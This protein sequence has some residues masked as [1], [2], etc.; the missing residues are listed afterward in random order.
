V[1]CAKTAELIKM[2]STLWTLVGPR[3]H[4]L[5]GPRS[6][7]EGAIIRGKDMPGHARR[8]SAVSCAKMA[9]SIDLPFV[10]WTWVCRMKHKFNRIHQ[11]AIMC[12]RGRAHWCHLANTIGPSVCSG[13]VALR[14]ITLTTCC[15]LTLLVDDRQYQIL[16]L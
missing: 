6:L 8:H 12:P 7:F 1:S 13:D 16:Y 4:V 2:S 9:G 11:V 14:Q 10:L 5:D 15:A 3:K